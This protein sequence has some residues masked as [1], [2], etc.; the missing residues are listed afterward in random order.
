MG[1]ARFGIPKSVQTE[2]D[3]IQSEMLTKLP[4][5]VKSFRGQ[6]PGKGRLDSFVNCESSWIKFAALYRTHTILGVIP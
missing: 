3:P 4:F 5:H 6:N 1:N 2:V